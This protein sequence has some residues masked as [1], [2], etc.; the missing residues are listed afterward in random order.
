MTI[1]ATIGLW[2][3]ALILISLLLIALPIIALIDIIQNEF[4]GQNKVI[5]I[6][7]VLLLPLLGTILYF[8]M[9]KTKNT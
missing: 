2:Q 1:L 8:I 6:L 3:T 7:V 5:W 9:R 4:A